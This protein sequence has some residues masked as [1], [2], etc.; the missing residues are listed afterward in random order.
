MRGG[1]R[2]VR[3]QFA[4]QPEIRQPA[5]RQPRS[6][7]LEPAVQCKIHGGNPD[8]I[9]RAQPRNPLRSRI[10]P[11]MR[12]LEPQRPCLSRIQGDAGSER[13]LFSANRSFQDEKKTGLPG[14]GEIF[15]IHGESFSF[16]QVPFVHALRRQ[17]PD[18]GVMIGVVDPQRQDA[19]PPEGG[20]GTEG[21]DFPGRKKRICADATDP[22]KTQ[23]NK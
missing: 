2:L 13:P 17:K 8:G 5:V 11:L 20:S 9:D 22:G 14:I 23:H 1:S 12:Q 15:D 10:E 6:G 21:L 16:R 18:G 7:F 4:L 3:N 19:V